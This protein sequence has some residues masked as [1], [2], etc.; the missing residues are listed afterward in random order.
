MPYGQSPWAGVADSFQNIG[1]GLANVMAARQAGGLRQQQFMAQQALERAYLEMARQKQAQGMQLQQARV[2][3]FQ[4]QSAIAQ[5]RAAQLRAQMQ[6]ADRLGDDVWKANMPQVPDDIN[7][8]IPNIDPNM[9][10]VLGETARMMALHG[11][12]IP[13]H[14]VPMENMAVNPYGGMIA[15]APQLS[16]YHEGQLR[17]GEERVDLQ[18]DFNTGRLDQGQQKIDRMMDPRVVQAIRV[19]AEMAKLQAGKRDTTDDQS[20]GQ[21]MDTMNQALSMAG[22]TN[23]P[24]SSTP[25]MTAVN[26]QTKQRIQSIDGGKT[27]NPVQ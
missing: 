19:L 9:A 5:E 25:P 17:L 15:Q 14:N 1:S 7:Q 11:K 6:S 2:P 23:R 21:G 20:F 24:A 26:P 13:L 12:T 8:P 16:P 4:A 18:R 3:L 22:V 27:W 10:R